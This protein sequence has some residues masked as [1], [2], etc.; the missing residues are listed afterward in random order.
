M[1][2]MERELNIIPFAA[3]NLSSFER[4]V[5]LSMDILLQFDVDMDLLCRWLALF[6]A[7]KE[8]SFKRPL[9]LDQYIGNDESPDTVNSLLPFIAIYCPSIQVVSVDGKSFEVSPLGSSS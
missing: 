8:V 9:H 3:P 2:L 1:E 4:I 6:P 5:G 7:L